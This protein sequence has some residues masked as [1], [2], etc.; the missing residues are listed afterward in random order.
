MHNAFM[1]YSEVVLLERKDGFALQY[2]KSKVSKY[3]IP[4]KII[5]NI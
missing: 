1:F 5:V 2:F 3:Y 4:E